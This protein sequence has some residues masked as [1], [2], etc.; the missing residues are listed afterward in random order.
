MLACNTNPIKCN[1]VRSYD[2]LVG[3]PS[4]NGKTLEGDISFE[5]LGLSAWLEEETKNFLT[6]SEL[7]EKLNGYIKTEGNG[8]NSEGFSIVG[9]GGASATSVT[10]GSISFL[11]DDGFSGS[12]AGFSYDNII[13]YNTKS[14]ESLSAGTYGINISSPE[15]SVTLDAATLRALINLL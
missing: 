8:S 2:D 10:Y 6:I 14:L 13:F 9:M 12:S 15:D 1:F 5:D 3:K 7:D 11:Y 4:I